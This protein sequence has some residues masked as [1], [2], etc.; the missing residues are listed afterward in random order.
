MEPM[1]QQDDPAEASSQNELAEGWFIY[2]I[3]QLELGLRAPLE[4]ATQEAGLTTA[5]FTAL[6]VL[7]RWPGLTSSEL[8]RR[9]FVRAQTM[10]ETITPLLEAGYVHRQRDA[11]GGRRFLLFLTET[12]RAALASIRGPVAALESDFLSDLL[13]HER[14]MFAT[15]LRAC[16]TTLTALPR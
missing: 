11:A 16:R 6:A 4:R 13:P 9:S 3:K 12:G 7:S 14:D 10:A 1:V 8:A 5:Q 15:Y 2:T